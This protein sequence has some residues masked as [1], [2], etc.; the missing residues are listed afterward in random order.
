MVKIRALLISI[1]LLTTGYLFSQE[2]TLSGKITDAETD[3][4]L[5][6]ANIMAAKGKGN[7]SD[8]DGNYSIKLKPGEYEI[9]V[10]FVGYE[11][12][13]KKI[14]LQ[15]NKELNFRLKPEILDEVKIVA[16]V[17]EFRETPVAFSS[18]K[19]K[20]IEEELGPQD[21][22]MLLNST[23]GAYA[24]QQGGGDGDAR[25]TIR[26]FSQRNIAIMINGVPVNDM[27]NGWVYWSNWFGLDIVTRD[28]QVQ[29]GLAASKL[30][31]PSV[32]GTMNII[33]KGIENRQ[34]AA[35]EQEFGSDGYLRTSLMYNSGDLGKG[36]GLTTAASY[37]QRN[38]WVDETWSKAGFFPVRQ[39]DIRPGRCG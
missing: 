38:G 1:F 16:D 2:Y 33:T 35:V 11:S 21:I 12:E 24:T 7:T 8:F 15:S 30:A 3:E 34:S 10:S 31:L 9:K 39:A 23:P 5:F 17:A 6:G 14:N 13:I 27:E 4:A 20:K 18:I 19:P 32:G 36:W 29:R 25:I 22:P 37:K 28:I 26:G